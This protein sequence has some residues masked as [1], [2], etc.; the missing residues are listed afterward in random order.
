MGYLFELVADDILLIALFTFML[1]KFIYKDIN[2]MKKDIDTLKKDMNEVKKDINSMP[3]KIIK[4][5]TGAQAININSPLSL[6]DLG[7]DISEKISAMEIANSLVESLTE[8][9]KSKSEYEIQEMCSDYIR[10]KY[11]PSDEILSKMHHQAY[12]TGLSLNQV[13]EVIAIELRDMLLVQ[14]KK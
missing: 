14:S 6:T 5:I 3:E 12:H 8:E 4:I 1:W 2:T 9:A 10:N 7:K 11:K 13:K